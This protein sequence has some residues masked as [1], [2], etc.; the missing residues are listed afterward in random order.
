MAGGQ[1]AKHAERVGD[2]DEGAPQ[3]AAVDGDD[4]QDGDQDDEQRD[5]PPPAAPARPRPRSRRTPGAAM[6]KLKE[7]LQRAPDEGSGAGGA[8][9]ET[10]RGRAPPKSTESG[11]NSRVGGETRGEPP[12]EG[13]GSGRTCSGRPAPSRGAAGRILPS[14]TGD[15]RNT[16]T[17]LLHESRA[18][19]EGNCRLVFPCA[20]SADPLVVIMCLSGGF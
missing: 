12:P 13:G 19:P 8:W 1:K 3:A 4:R 17:T 7:R 9:A 5:Q 2:P 15:S 6:Q 16:F 14:S 10:R 11:R 18:D 20:R